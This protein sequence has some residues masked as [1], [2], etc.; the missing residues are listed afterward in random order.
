[1]HK[2][3]NLPPSCAA[4]T[5]SGSLNFLEPSGPLGPVTGLPLLCQQNYLNY[6]YTDKEVIN[7]KI[8]CFKLWCCNDNIIMINL[9]CCK[10]IRSFLVVS[11]VSNNYVR[12][13]YTLH[14]I[15]CAGTGQTSR[16]HL[17]CNA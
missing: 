10:C 13:V 1:M 16:M 3:D 11:C 14:S 12:V 4:V 6:K 5:K 7:L 9:N 2:A 8:F 17:L 15:H